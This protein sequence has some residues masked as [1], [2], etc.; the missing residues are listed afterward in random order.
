MQNTRSR[1]EKRLAQLLTTTPPLAARPAPGQPR[2]DVVHLSLADQ[3]RLDM[4][5][6]E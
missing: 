5:L 6:R 4:C 3:D 1:L 2:I